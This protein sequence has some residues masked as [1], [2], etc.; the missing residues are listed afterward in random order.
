VWTARSICMKIRQIVGKKISFPDQNRAD[1][2]GRGPFVS[3]AIGD[4]LTFSTIITVF[5]IFY[6]YYLT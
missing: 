1:W 4:A 5:N 3:K 2:D 6:P